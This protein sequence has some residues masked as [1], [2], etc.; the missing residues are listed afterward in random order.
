MAFPQKV[1]D[2]LSQAPSRTPGGLKQLLLLSTLLFLISAASYVG[3]S[4]GYKK[5]L[6]S[7]IQKSKQEI[8]DFSQQVSLEDQAKLINFYAQLLNLKSLLNSHIKLS[9]VFAWLET[10][11][12]INTYFQNFRFDRK[13]N[14]LSLSATSKTF[15]DMA[16]QILAFENLKEQVEKISVSNISSKTNIWQYNLDLTLSPSFLS[17]FNISEDDL[18][19][20]ENP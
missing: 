20:T 9:P 1:T 15:T 8:A 17:Q 18:S 13:T 3:L 19:E 14:S 6:E 7:S 4:F 12:Q 10:N 16:E 2:R 11:S 5:Y